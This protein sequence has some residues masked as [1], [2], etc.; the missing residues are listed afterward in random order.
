MIK[1]IGLLI[2]LALVILPSALA[3][4]IDK[5]F[6][7]NYKSDFNIIALKENAI[8]KIVCIYVPVSKKLPDFEDCLIQ[9]RSK[10]TFWCGE[11]AIN[12]IYD[13]PNKAILGGVKK[14]CIS[15]LK[16][17]KTVQNYVPTSKKNV[18]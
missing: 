4:N 5:K 16:M 6:A 14:P 7:R 10:H 9:E 1:R 8:T 12:P 13:N 3:N 2:L 17:I 11:V 18:A 15:V